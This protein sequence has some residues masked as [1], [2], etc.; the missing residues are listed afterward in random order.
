M[1]LP[2]AEIG[3]IFVIYFHAQ[4]LSILL[5]KNSQELLFEQIFSKIVQIFVYLAYIS[6]FCITKNSNTI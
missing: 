5:Y 3:T 4:K 6:H 1:D 2:I